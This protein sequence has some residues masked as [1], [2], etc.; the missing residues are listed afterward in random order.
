MFSVASA[1]RHLTLG[2]KYPGHRGFRPVQLKWR[3]ILCLLI[4]AERFCSLSGNYR[5]VAGAARPTGYGTSVH[6]G[7]ADGFL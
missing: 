3:L 5:S 2:T 4:F 6:S 7:E 1:P